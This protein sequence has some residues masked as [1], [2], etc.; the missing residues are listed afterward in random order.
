[1]SRS[2]GGTAIVKASAAEDMT[3]AWS[4]SSMAASWA[5]P[6]VL[7][8][9]YQDQI[10]SVP[11]PLHSKISVSRPLRRR[12]RYCF[13]GGY[14]TACCKIVCKNHLSRIT[15]TGWTET[16]RFSVFVD[17][18][19]SYGV[20]STPPPHSTEGGPSVRFCTVSSFTYKPEL[21]CWR[22]NAAFCFFSDR[23]QDL[24]DGLIF[25]NFDVNG[26][27]LVRELVGLWF[28][29]KV[30]PSLHVMLAPGST[31]L[32][33][34]FTTTMS[35]RFPQELFDL[36]IDHARYDEKA[37]KN[38]STVCK[39]WTVRSHSHFFDVVFFRELHPRPVVQR[40]TP[41]HRWPI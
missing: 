1:M 41:Y 35:P 26:L 18:S 4:S 3:V 5:N 25:S 34:N 33:S 12:I 8:Q 30:V 10:L 11:D 28:W 20:W 23:F 19:R 31:S 27:T 36:I 9:P 21:A 16:A 39:R 40:N 29:S 17:E 6:P 7:V 14:G 38:Y 22:L 32:V 13:E 24:V 37:L 2:L 15:H